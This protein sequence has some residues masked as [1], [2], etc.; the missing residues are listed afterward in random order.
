MEADPR[1]LHHVSLPPPMLSPNQAHATLEEVATELG[2]SRQRVRQ[3]ER[4]AL[5]KLRFELEQRG[6]SFEDLSPGENSHEWE[7]E[8]HKHE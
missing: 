1:S 2:I 6:L 4:A 7:G 3:I 5:R 8:R